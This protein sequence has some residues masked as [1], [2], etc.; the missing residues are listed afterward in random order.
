MSEF[1]P[2]NM[3]EVRHAM[4]DFEDEGK[5][6]DQEEFIAKTVESLFQIYLNQAEDGH[7]DTAKL[8]QPDLF[9]VVDIAN[10]VIYE[11]RSTSASF[12]AD[13][14][15]DSDKLLTHLEDVAYNVAAQ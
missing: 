9:Q 2:E 13:F 5:S 4:L 6:V 15:D 3:R 10:N 1:I 12:V 8:V 14:K 11:E 7:Y